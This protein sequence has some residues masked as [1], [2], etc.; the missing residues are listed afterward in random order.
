MRD[1]GLKERTASGRVGRGLLVHWVFSQVKTLWRV[2]SLIEWVRMQ[3][4][5][6]VCLFCCVTMCRPCLRYESLRLE[7]VTKRWSRSQEVLKWPL[8][9]DPSKGTVVESLRVKEMDSNG[10]NV[11]K[12]PFS[13]DCLSFPFNVHFIRVSI[14][15][16]PPASFCDRCEPPLSSFY[17]GLTE[18]LYLS[19][20]QSWKNKQENRGLEVQ[21]KESPERIR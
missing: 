4:N 5:L 17:F 16:P 12:R 21:G 18:A 11:L 13:P 3:V 20:Q 1:G 15:T 7:I 9:V 6:C 14:K 8:S 19:V 2:W 10:Q